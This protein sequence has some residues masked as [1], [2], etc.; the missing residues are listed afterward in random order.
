M[1][2]GHERQRSQHI[3]GQEDEQVAKDKHLR[4]NPQA[5]A[6]AGDFGLHSVEEDFETLDR[7]E[8]F[9]AIAFA[10]VVVGRCSGD[11]SRSSTAHLRYKDRQFK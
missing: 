8:D 3:E 5:A 7:V 1:G 6:L 4:A 10:Y 9:V 11:Q 2:L